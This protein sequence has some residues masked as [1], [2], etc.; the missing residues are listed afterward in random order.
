M[1]T[2][3]SGIVVLLVELGVASEMRGSSGWVVVVGE[4]YLVAFGL[5]VLWCLFANCCWVVA[6]CWLVDKEFGVVSWGGH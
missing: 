4:W 2:F 6:R 3:G 5:G 1:I